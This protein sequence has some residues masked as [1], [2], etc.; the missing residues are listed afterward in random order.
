MQGG[1]LQGKIGEAQGFTEKHGEALANIR[2]ENGEEKE[3]G[4]R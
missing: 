2:K 4:R 3:E 1:Q